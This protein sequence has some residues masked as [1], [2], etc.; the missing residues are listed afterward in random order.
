MDRGTFEEQY[1]KIY[2]DM[3]RFALYTLCLLYTSLP[4]FAGSA[5]PRW[6]NEAKGCFLGLTLAHD[7]ACMARACVEGITMEQRDIM[8]SIDVSGLEFS[9][10]RIVGGATKSEIW[11]QI[12]ADIYKIPCETLKVTDAA[13]LGAAICAGAGVGAFAGIKDCLLY[14]SRC[15]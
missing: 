11:N 5:A 9:C 15:V 7:R 10:A 2:Q 1:K 12:Q 6:N 3:Y 8:E 4:Y 14:T 13:A